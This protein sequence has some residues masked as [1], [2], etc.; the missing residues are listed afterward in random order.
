MYFVGE[1]DYFT[2]LDKVSRSNRAIIPIS[3]MDCG[4]QPIQFHIEHPKH[5]GG[6]D[7]GIF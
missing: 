2:L 1:V 4:Y 6:K 5:L 7:Y 3:F